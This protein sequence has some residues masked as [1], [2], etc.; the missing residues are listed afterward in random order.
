ML[1]RGRHILPQAKR[2]LAK[3][4]TADGSQPRYPVAF[5][6]NGGGVTERYKA[7]QLSE[8]LGVAV[9]ESQVVLSHTPFRQL[10]AQ[11][12]DEPVLVAGR[13]QVREVARHYGF[14]RVIT[15]QQLVRAMP[16]AVPFR[17]DQG[18]LP[19]P[20]D[21]PSYTRDLKYGSL[22]HPIKAAFVFT[23]PSDWYRDLQL[24]LDV[25]TSGGAPGHTL[26]PGAPHPEIYFSNPDLLWAN[27]FPA[28]RL[29]QG[30]FSACLETLYKEVTGR[31]L[32][33]HHFGKPHAA[34]YLLAEQLL[35]A[36]AEALGI[37]MLPPAAESAG[38]HAAGTAGGQLA[39]TP[40]PF[41][42]IYAVG[43]NP[44]A[45]VAGA[46]SAGAPWVSVLVTQTGVAREDCRKNCAQLVVA[47]VEAAVDAA[48]HRMRHAMW[49]SMR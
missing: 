30:A 44:A 8:W 43:D 38:D 40:L 26:T 14:R 2:A 24:L 7:H 22:E 42:A 35:L 5:L 1:V 18:W 6:T 21:L 16:A 9:D 29:G 48:L 4:Y 23:D 3:L 41:S 32:K 11:Y 31:P 15:P 17:E 36:Q 47:D 39:R 37:D 25:L 34:P 19:G 46:N 28:P 20:T 10:V 12:G 33:A 49:H 45:D 27:E 13:G